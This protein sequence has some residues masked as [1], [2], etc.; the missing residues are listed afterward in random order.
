MDIVFSKHAE[1]QMMRRGIS[2]ETVLSAISKPDEIVTDEGDT[3]IVVY[4]SLIEDN[5]IQFLLRVFINV[6]KQP[7]VIVT[8]YRTTKI[9]KYYE[10][11]I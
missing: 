4:Q 9:R 5:G 3:S 11:K 1:E 10:S 2:K 8:L 7:H 6:N